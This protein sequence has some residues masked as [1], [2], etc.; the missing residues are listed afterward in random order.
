MASHE[1]R[2][3]LQGAARGM[4]RL[5]RKSQLP[6]TRELACRPARC[7]PSMRL[8]LASSIPSPNL[9]LPSGNGTAMGA[10]STWVTPVR[11]LSPISRA[12]AGDWCRRPSSGPQTFWR[13]RRRCRIACGR[14]DR[15]PVS[16]RVIGGEVSQPAGARSIEPSWKSAQR[17]RGPQGPSQ[18]PERGRPTR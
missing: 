12:V 16:L 15:A 9:I 1:R 11:R 10:T 7:L 5:H 6:P 4:F 2:R 13:R 8:L 17:L 3:D 18:K 14:C